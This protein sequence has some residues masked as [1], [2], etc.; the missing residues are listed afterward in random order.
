MYI[1]YVSTCFFN[2]KSKHEEDRN[3][4][5]SKRKREETTRTI[6]M[7]QTLTST[8]VDEVET[9]R[10]TTTPHYKP[11]TQNN[12]GIALKTNRLKDKRIRYESHKDFLSRCISEELMPKGL[13][14]KLEPTNG[15]FDQEFVDTW[16][17]QPSQELLSY[18]NEKHCNLL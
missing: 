13:K 7:E 18:P 14:L 3:N 11:P 12:D 4:R 16:Y 17:S 10:T 2:S 15:N 5:T 6:L 1:Y 8:L 9:A